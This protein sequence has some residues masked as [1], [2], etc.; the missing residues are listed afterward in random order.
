MFLPD[1]ITDRTRASLGDL[2]PD[3]AASDDE[4]C[5][6]KW[7]SMNPQ[8]PHWCVRVAGHGD[9]RHVSTGHMIWCEPTGDE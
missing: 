1:P 7:A 9:G 8:D 3:I 2:F 6:V 5:H 4:R